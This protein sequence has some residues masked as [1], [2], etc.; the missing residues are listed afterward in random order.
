LLSEL[1]PRLESLRLV[2]NALIRPA[3]S[4]NQ[5]LGRSALK[6]AD[7]FEA[8]SARVGMGTKVLDHSNAC[9]LAARSY[10]VVL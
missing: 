2:L 3:L 5:V 1:D 6:Q 9:G 10:R 4:R 7:C 8:Y